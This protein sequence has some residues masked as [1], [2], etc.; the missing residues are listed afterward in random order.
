MTEVEHIPQS[1]ALDVKKLSRFE[2]VGYRS[3]DLTSRDL[4]L[5]GLGSGGLDR[6]DD[7]D[8]AER[9][10]AE[11]HP[12]ARRLQDLP[13]QRSR[14]DGDSEPDEG[15]HAQERAQLFRGHALA[16]FGL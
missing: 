8:G 5:L 4:G 11:R 3:S 12:P 9:Q 2:R 13:K 16:Q 15:L 6:S 10:R 1:G 7:D 14:D